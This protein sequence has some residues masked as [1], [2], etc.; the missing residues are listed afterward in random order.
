MVWVGAK[1]VLSG[2]RSAAAAFAYGI[3]GSPS[4]A[5]SEQNEHRVDFRADRV[6]LS[7]TDAALS[8]SG[9]V[10]VRSDRF[11]L[12]GDAVTLTRSPRGIHVEGAG[13]LAFCSCGYPPIALGFAAADLAPP[14]D[15]L[16]EGA[17][18]RVLGVPVLYSPILWLRS[19]DRPGLLPPS[20]AYRGEEGLL[21]GTGVHV[22]LGV[23]G[24]E[25]AVLDIGYSAYLAGGARFSTEARGALGRAA[26]LFDFFRGSSVDLETEFAE[27]SDASG[28]TLVGR[29]DVRRGRR[30]LVSEL[31]VQEVARPTDRARLAVG[32]AR[33]FVLGLSVRA[34]SPRGSALDAEPSFGPV[35]ELGHTVPLGPRGTASFL[36]ET[37]ALRTGEG[38]SSASTLHGEL[39]TALTVGAV[40]SQIWLRER[41]RFVSDPRA[42]G[43]SV[44]G[45]LRARI[46][47]PLARRFAELVHRLEPLVEAAVESV[48]HR[49]EGEPFHELHAVPDRVTLLAGLET[50]AGVH[51]EAAD[52]RVAAGVS[53]PARNPDGVLAARARAGFRHLYF[54]ADARAVP[55]RRAADVFVRAHAGGESFRIGAYV[56][57][58][59]ATPASAERLFFEDFTRP[60]LPWL[61]TPGFSGGGSLRFPTGLGIHTQLAVDV[62]LTRERLLGGSAALGYRHVCD[63]LGLALWSG[64]RIGREGVDVALRVDLVP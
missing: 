38:D 9:D 50:S 39:G 49:G 62:D 1:R 53:G 17:T 19:K 43:A 18:L 12:S 58:R 44:Q 15:V 26:F 27:T 33:D 30:A 64:R 7:T 59:Q 34:S 23:G 13:R 22:P 56:E 29:V 52:L 57:G 10:V 63:C 4:F 36:M 51:R 42:H 28:A 21:V 20:V 54:D 47:L 45:E 55:G 37:H 8:L 61:A 16:L 32:S 31:S 5:Q 2:R 41:S 24:V 48:R 25:P 11:Q 14:T 6:E 40:Q 46:T 60:E 3:A 35:L